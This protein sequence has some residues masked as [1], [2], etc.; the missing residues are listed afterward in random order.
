MKKV[1]IFPFLIIAPYTTSHSQDLVDPVNP[2]YELMVM[3]TE[4]TYDACGNR[5]GRSLVAPIF[6]D[7]LP[8]II[9]WNVGE[10]GGKTVHLS[11]RPAQGELGVEIIGF[12]QTDNCAIGIYDTNGHTL[13]MQSINAAS[14][15]IQYN[16]VKN[17]T[18]IIQLK[19][20]GETAAWMITDTNN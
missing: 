11:P 1:F 16:R 5:I 10:I 15:D 12:E 6:H 20:N 19:L 2:G 18:D 8:G 9:V 13:T 3:P 14:T 7:S 17:Q 4:Y